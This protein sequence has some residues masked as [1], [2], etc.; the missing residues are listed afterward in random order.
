MTGAQVINSRG[1]PRVLVVSERRYADQAQPRGLL[2]AI[3]ELGVE[4]REHSLADDGMLAAVLADLDWADVVVARGRS[5]QV[6]AALDSAEQ[7]GVAVVDSPGSIRAVR[8]KALMGAAF[9][10]ANIRIPATFVA[11]IE[12]LV[13][14]VPSSRYPL[15]LKP[16]FGDN[17]RGLRVVHTPEDLA[18]VDWPESPALAQ[19]YLPSDGLDLKLYGIGAQVWAIRKPSPFTPCRYPGIFPVPVNAG[20]QRLALTCAALFGL[21]VFGVDCL[22][23]PTG[24][25]VIEVNDFPNFTAVPGADAA[26]AAHVLA[27]AGARTEV[28]A[29]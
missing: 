13:D 20:L 23:T 17:S 28:G 18:L 16:I 15:I 24:P 25:V 14:V 12:V 27:A 6:L 5:E 11:A 22:P 9:M 7:L 10:E 29:S 3:R 2:A 21:T 19:S 1:K 8:D 26:L 4:L